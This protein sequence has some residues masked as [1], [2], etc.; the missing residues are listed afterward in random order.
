MPAATGLRSRPA[1]LLIAAAL[2][3]SLVLGLSYVALH[4]FREL[5]GAAVDPVAQ[6][7][8]DEQAR[9]Q[10]VAPAREIVGTAKLDGVSASY[11]LMSCKNADE[12]PYQGAI[13]LNF[14]VPGVLDTPKY[15]RSIAAALVAGGWA[16]AMPPNR[17]PGGR[18][19]TRAG[20]TVIFYRNT[21]LA[22]RATMQIYGE[23]RN[24]SDHRQD[25]TGWVDVTDALLR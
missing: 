9:Q 5:R 15:F 11:L 17:H 2:L 4:R 25:T 3:I 21:D 1:V 12:P 14:D 16:E 20:V 23:C 6:P 18:T 24:V 19:F 10:V 7:L 8:T 22:D 13:Y